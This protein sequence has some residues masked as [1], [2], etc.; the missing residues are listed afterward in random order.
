MVPNASSR[1]VRVVAV[2]VEAVNDVV[3]ETA[4]GVVETV[5]KLRVSIVVAEVAITE[6]LVKTRTASS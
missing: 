3:A 4:N 2:E 5:L 6:V 1:E